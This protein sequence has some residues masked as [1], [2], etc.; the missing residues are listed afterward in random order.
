MGAYLT[1][2]YPVTSFPC[3][4]RKIGRV[5]SG[6][7]CKASEKS[8]AFAV[9]DDP[10]TSVPSPLCARMLPYGSPLGG[11]IFYYLIDIS[12]SGV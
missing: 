7:T 6:L 10:G 11:H 2:K 12:S 1:G 5:L 3:C 8:C 4:K 9:L